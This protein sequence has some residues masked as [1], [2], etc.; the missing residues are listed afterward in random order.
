[1]SVTV[2]AV[3]PTSAHVT[4]CP[5][6]RYDRTSPAAHAPA[7]TPAPSPATARG[8]FAAA[9]AAAHAVASP[10]AAVVGS[11][12]PVV[13]TAHASCS[14]E[15]TEFRTPHIWPDLSPPNRVAHPGVGS[16]AAGARPVRHPRGRR[17]RA[18]PSTNP[19]RWPRSRA[20]VRGGEREFVPRVRVPLAGEQ[21]AVASRS[22]EL[23]ELAEEGDALGVGE[24]VVGE[25]VDDGVGRGEAID[26][27]VGPV[28]LLED[29][30]EGGSAAS[31]VRSSYR[32]RM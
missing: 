25:L 32:R 29:A 24:V 15:E 3:P 5:L 6:N 21:R 4:Q 8:S 22:V 11:D 20:G 23:G 14:A 19:G 31:T 2:P 12:P 28:G 27:R 16:R 1:M 30:V 9:F 7:P 17:R 18:A 13:N 10:A 26:G